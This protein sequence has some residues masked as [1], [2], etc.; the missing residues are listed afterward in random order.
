VL[1]GGVGGQDGVVGLN[2][3]GRDLRSG[4]D[5]ELKLRLLAIVNA[6]TLHEERGETGSSTTTER[7]EDQET[8]ETGALV[9]QLPDSV[10][11]KVNQLLSYGV[12]TTSVVVGSVFLAGDELLWVEQLPVGTSS[13]LIY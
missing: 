7:V 12:V 3:S 5:G 8:L 11:N 13:Y 1:Q 10:K 9:S 6:E 4:V 2:H